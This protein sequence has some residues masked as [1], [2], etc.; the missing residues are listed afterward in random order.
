[1]S[2]KHGGKREGAGRKSTWGF[3]GTS[4][5][6]VRLPEPV[7]TL[8]L[9]LRDLYQ[10]DDLIVKIK[11]SMTT[12]SIMNIPTESNDVINMPTYSYNEENERQKLYDKL[13]QARDKIEYQRHKNYQQGLRDG[14]QS[15]TDI[16]V[17]HDLEIIDKLYPE[18]NKTGKLEEEM[19]EE[20]LLKEKQLE[21][22][23]LQEKCD[24]PTTK[25]ELE[26]FKQK[27]KQS[28]FWDPNRPNTQEAVCRYCKS[29][30]VTTLPNGEKC[31]S[32]SIGAYLKNL[33]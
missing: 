28:E 1:M 26:I 15:A 25:T 14:I 2:K 4:L 29:K 31:T 11:S 8:L 33:K 19:T 3:D 22:N 9:E 5:K 23:F 27:L 32:R 20:E 16:I 13:T 10:G 6:N 17:D 7:W 18:N 24:L 30:G 21:L 12:E